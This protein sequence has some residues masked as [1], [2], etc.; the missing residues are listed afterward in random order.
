MKNIFVKWVG[1]ATVVVIFILSS[2]WIFKNIKIDEL[3]GQAVLEESKNI[4]ETHEDISEEPGVP[5]KFKKEIK[6]IDNDIVEMLSPDALNLLVDG[7]K[8]EGAEYISDLSL[9]PDGKKFCF[10]VH[11]IVPVWLY[12]YDLENEELI[13]VD[14]G[15][16]CYWSP[17]GNYVAYNNHT[18]DVSPINVLV[19]ELNTGKIKNLSE[20]IV[21]T[22]AFVQCKDIF[23]ED[24]NKLLFD[25]DE[26]DMTDVSSPKIERSYTYDLKT[27]NLE[28]IE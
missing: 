6:I 24:E 13:K 9:S 14:V 15:K 11:T 26:I 18:T 3:F 12:L 16:N 27:K 1:F 2:F 8:I 19:Y 25:C 5:E 10:L 28:N 7:D 22:D 21:S 4:E 17:N 23:W 20:N